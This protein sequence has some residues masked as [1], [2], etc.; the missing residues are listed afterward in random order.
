VAGFFEDLAFQVLEGGD[1]SLAD[2]FWFH[3]AT[4]A[5]RLTIST[6]VASS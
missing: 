1:F 5:A 6:K 2:S 4:L 3:E